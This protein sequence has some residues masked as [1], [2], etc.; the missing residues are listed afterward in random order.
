MTRPS[1]RADPSEIAAIVAA[2]HGDPFGVLGP[3]ETGDGR[4]IRAFIP[5]ART[6]AAE[7][8]QGRPVTELELVH[9]DGFFEGLASIDPGA[10]YVLAASNGQSQ[11]RLVDPYAFPPFLGAMDDHLFVEGAHRKLYERLG[12]HVVRHMGVEGTN[13]AVWAPNARRVSVVGDFNQWDGRRAQMRKR[14]DSGIWE[15]FLPGVGSGAVYKYEILGRDGNLLP[16]KADPFGFEA[17]LRPS[18]ASVVAS[19]APYD[20]GDEKH[21]RAR[22]ERDPRRAPMSIYEVHLPSWRKADGWR[23]LTYDELADQLI[24]YA[25]DMGFTHI[26]LLPINEHPLDASWGYQPIGLFAPTRRHGDAEGFK[27]FVD[28]AHQAGLGVVLDWVPAHFPTD[29]HGLAQFDGGPLYEHP[30]PR[31][32]F[33]PDWNTAIYDYGR[34]EVAN[35]LIANALYWLDRFHIDALRVDAVASMLYLDYSRAPGEWAPNPD[36]SNDNKD[37]VAFLQNVNT[38]VYG[39]YPGVVTIAEESTSWAGV[40]RPVDM[41]GLGFGF[42]WNMGWMNDTLRYMSSDPVYR[43]WRHNEITFGLLYAFAENFVLPLSHDEVVHGKGAIVSKMPGDEW[44]RFAGARAYYGFMWGHP[45]KKLLF[46]GQEFGQTSEWDY[47]RELEWGLL[48]HAFH[49]G[50]RDFVRDLNHLYRSHEALH[51]RDCES[52]GFEWVVVDDAESSVFAF[53]R[54]GSDRTR[55]I[56]V[57]SNFTPVPRRHYRL[58][59]PYAG[60]WR[61]ILNSDAS[62]YGGSGQGNLG[63]VDA[64]EE[65]FAGFPAMAEIQIPPLATL[66]F[67]FDNAG[68]Q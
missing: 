23:F 62:P 37:A 57:V 32:G 42:K 21:L 45:G 27:R 5:G 55:P 7:T 40:T 44:R 49:K 19:D 1:W 20:W 3:H 11:W 48:A 9:P 33:H 41:G 36:G 15:I 17:E 26:E 6:L 47:A 63:G 46:M 43:K 35:F 22:A 18:T 54:Y 29:E 61:E 59:L 30:D 66:F 14:V 2:R 51:A 8:P 50:L 16:L 31:R 28:R 12:A 25:A 58:G 10:P 24:P 39:L 64:K 4:V 65:G 60:R 53:L 52:E 38:L 56:L 13:F 68:L 67:E 34:R